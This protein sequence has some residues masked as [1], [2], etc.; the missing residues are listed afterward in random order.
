[1]PNPIRT[2]YDYGEGGYN[3]IDKIRARNKKR[4]QNDAEDMLEDKMS[5]ELIELADYLDSA[6][7]GKE[8]DAIDAIIRKLASTY[9]ED[10]EDCNSLLGDL[11][12]IVDNWNKEEDELFQNEETPWEQIEAMLITRYEQVDNAVDQK[13][14]QIRDLCG[15][16]FYQKHVTRN[17]RSIFKDKLMKL[18]RAV[19]RKWLAGSTSGDA[20]KFQDPKYV[21]RRERYYQRKRE[22]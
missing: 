1:M 2:N 11:S 14:Q 4:K 20:P 22:Q 16:Q 10:R 19:K 8:A 9:E 18:R 3:F 15:E 7:M 21:G 12:T 13:E 17:G 5:E 6:G